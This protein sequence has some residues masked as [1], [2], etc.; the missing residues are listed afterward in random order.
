V[1]ANWFISMT[2]KNH[3]RAFHK[4]PYFAVCVSFFAHFLCLPI[5]VVC[6]ECVNALAFRLEVVSIIS[7]RMK[8][9]TLKC[10][11]LQPLLQYMQF[12]YRQWQHLV[13]SLM[14]LLWPSSRKVPRLL[15]L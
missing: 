8:W 6:A 1:L 2:M 15:E 13:V 3:N 4:C 7:G 12:P 5:F 9:G 14:Q 11:H 10:R